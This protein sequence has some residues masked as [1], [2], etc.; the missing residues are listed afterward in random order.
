MHR[1]YVVDIHKFDFL[2]SD[3]TEAAIDLYQRLGLRPILSWMAKPNLVKTMSEGRCVGYDNT[4]RFVIQYK[5]DITTQKFMQPKTCYL[6]F[7]CQQLCDI[8]GM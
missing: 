5:Y 4:Y 6:R 2:I 8:C 7:T 3:T 1:W